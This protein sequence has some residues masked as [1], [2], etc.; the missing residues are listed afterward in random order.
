MAL[1]VRLGHK[2]ASFLYSERVHGG[3]EGETE[4]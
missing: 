3:N 2:I 1:N 4:Y